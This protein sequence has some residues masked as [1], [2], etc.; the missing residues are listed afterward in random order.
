MRN[1]DDIKITVFGDSIFKGIVTDSGKLQKLENSVVNN[2][3][4]HFNLDIKNV[5]VYGQTLGRIYQKGLILDYTN[6]LDTSKK[7]ITVL[8]V[9]GNDSDYDWQEIEKSPT[10]PH[11]PKTTLDEFKNILTLVINQ[12]KCA[13]AKVFVTTIPPVD[14]KRYFENV[15]CKIADRNKILEFFN[16]DVNT[17]YRHQE[18]FNDAIMQ[19]AKKTCTGV[20]DIRTPFLSRLDFLSL[21]CN[22]GIHPN[23]NGHNLMTTAIIKQIEDKGDIYE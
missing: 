12:I 3:A 7:N 8:S 13:G 9:G 10:L 19:V 5:S 22:D 2:V 4:K 17:I 21:M 15:I 14:S 6:S 18:L 23:Q 16:G 1:F 20:I 11:K